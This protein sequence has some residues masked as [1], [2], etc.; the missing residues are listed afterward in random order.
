MKAVADKKKANNIGEYI[1]YM[2]Q[3]EDL[4]RAYQFNLKDI[5]TYVIQHYPVSQLE[6]EDT[7]AWFAE[8][9]ERMQKE[10]LQEAGHLSSTQQSVDQLALL[11]W[12]LLKV[13]STYFAI[14]QNA[15]PH[16]MEL[17]LASQNNPPKHEIQ[18]CINGIYGLLIARLAG[19]D[20]KEEML[21]ATNA[22]GDVLSYLNRIYFIQENEQV[23]SN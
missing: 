4:I 18:T 14:Y 5:E 13:D 2:Y 20:V 21:T 15:K 10:G 22:F 19:K 12:N 7:A 8:M 9:A 3:M 16:V 17:I 11:H 23:R 1:I 6:K